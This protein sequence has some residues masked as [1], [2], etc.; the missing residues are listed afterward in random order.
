MIVIDGSR[1]AIG[2]VAALAAGGSSMSVDERARRRAADAARFAAVTAASR[3]LY[4]RTTGVGANRTIRPADPTAYALGLLRS[5]ATSAGPLRAPHRVRAMLAVRLNQLLAGG[6]G[7]P[8]E[9]ADALARMLADDSLPPVHELGSVGTGDLP[10]LAVTRL[11]LA[12]LVD[13]TPPL[14]DPVPVDIGDALAFISSNAAALADAALALHELAM[15]ADAAVTVAALTHAALDG[16]PEAF[17]PPVERTTPFAGARRV[18]EALRGHLAGGAPAARI[19]D[20]FGLRALPQ[21]HGALLDRLDELDAVV[22]TMI[23]AP[24]ENPLLLPDEPGDDEVAGR[25]GG[26]AHH[27]A[28]HA[29]SLAQALDSTRSAL[30]QAGQLGLNRLTLYADPGMTTVSP[31]L[32]DGTAGSSGTMI[33]EYV[34]ASALAELRAA[35]APVAVQTVNLS[36]GV[37]EDASFASL[38]ASSALALVPSYRTLVACELV[39]AVRCLRMRATIVPPPLAG[40]FEHCAKLPS[41]LTDRDL[42]E[43]I[44][45]AEELLADLAGQAVSSSG[46]SSSA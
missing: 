5:H 38:A 8:A 19:Q 17:A 25:R 32:S 7:V 1:L 40:V 4:G 14:R 41:E 42:T 44:A 45:A 18:C 13:T 46:R 21:V 2:D 31:F 20:P 34:A 29:A 10:A 43:D 28:F 39:D 11:A 33:V 27:A 23:N 37:E 6:S 9:V 12:G 15:L 3:P 30:A 24:T 35:S 22:T 26:V 16:N 36:R